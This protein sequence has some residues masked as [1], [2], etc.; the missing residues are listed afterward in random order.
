MNVQQVREIGLC[1]GKRGEPIPKKGENMKKLFLLSLVF[2]WVIGAG[3]LDYIRAQQEPYKIGVVNNETGAMGM[4]G[5]VQDRGIRLAAEVINKEG[6]VNGHHIEVIIYDG[7]SKPDV[8]LRMGRKLISQ[9]QVKALIGPNFTPGIAAMSSVINE[10][11]VPMMKFGGYVADPKKDPYI[12]ST[13]QDNRLIA[14]S[15]VEWYR[16]KGVKKLAIIAVKSAYGEEFTKSYQDYLA[17]YPDMTVTAVEW[18]MPEDTDITPQMTKLI[19][20]K[21]D[22]I[23]SSTAG[24]H[25]ILTVKTAAKLGWKGP[26]GVTHGDIAVSFAEALKDLPTGYVWAPTRR[27]GI[28]TVV[29]SMPPGPVKDFNLKIMNA[30]R[31]KFGTLKDVEAGSLGYEHADIFARAFKSVGY[32]AEK[33]KQWLESNDIVTTSMI[34]RMSPNDH[35]GSNPKDWTAIT[36]TEGGDFV[37]AK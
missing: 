16:N 30:W 25:S 21:P 3:A 10:A 34:I 11:K 33:I 24:A 19:A 6:G 15:M 18:F 2:I 37:L 1:V 23:G 13:G 36:T 28:P 29:E 9:D 14:Q 32:D 31:A 27:G 5:I 17:K 8:C 20:S 26:V 12:F 22:V 7:E 35:C 4:F